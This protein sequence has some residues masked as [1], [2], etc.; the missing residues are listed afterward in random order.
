MYISSPTLYPRLWIYLFTCLLF[1]FTWMAHT[2]LILS[3]GKVKSTTRSVSA[4]S[5]CELTTFPRN[6]CFYVLDLGWW[7]YCPL[8]VPAHNHRYLWHN[9]MR[10]KSQGALTKN[11][12]KFSPPPSFSFH[13][14]GSSQIYLALLHPHHCLSLFR[15]HHFSP[16]LLPPNWF[17]GL[18]HHTFLIHH[19]HTCQSDF[20]E[21]KIW[22]P[23]FLKLFTD[24]LLPILNL[25][26]LT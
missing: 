5:H 15:P 8:H 9:E 26:S 19:L 24:S 7:H 12:S 2:R 16:G 3:K 13:L 14:P 20:S 17:P 4:F 21:M 23:L 18:H 10:L 6:L 11:P 22:S 1:I 25:S